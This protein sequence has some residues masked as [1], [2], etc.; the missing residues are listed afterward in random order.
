MYLLQVNLSGGWRTLAR[1]PDQ[2]LDDAL[3]ACDRAVLTYK[4]TSRIVEEL[5]VIN[6]LH[7][8]DLY[9]FRTVYE[10]QYNVRSDPDENWRDDLPEND[11][12]LDWR[13]VGF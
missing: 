8:L 12:S 11:L 1:Y 13:E 6:G 9:E 5:E 3:V 10:Q 4:F 7:P 2:Y